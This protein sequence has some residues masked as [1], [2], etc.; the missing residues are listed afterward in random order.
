[1]EYILNGFHYCCEER[2]F[3]ITCKIVIYNLMAI[4]VLALGKEIFC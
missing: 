2:D 1:M 4:G 3:V